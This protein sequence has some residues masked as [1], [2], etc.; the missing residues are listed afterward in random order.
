MNR[1]VCAAPT[2]GLALA[3]SG[4]LHARGSQRFRRSPARLRC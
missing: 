1:A 4:A 3:W 2:I